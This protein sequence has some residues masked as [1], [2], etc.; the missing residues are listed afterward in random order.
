M[1]Q[2]VKLAQALVHDP[3]LVLLDEPTNGLDPQGRDEMLAL[4]QRVAHEMGINVILTSHVLADVERVANYVVMIS[5]GR[6]VVQGKLQDLM[7]TIPTISVRTHED[8]AAFAAAL[9]RRG[10]QPR[11]DEGEL[12]LDSQEARSSTLSVT[13]PWRPVPGSSLSSSAADPGGR[14]SQWRCGR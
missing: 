2:R 13:P 8:P 3:R 10:F 9:R 12:L 4:I 7:S 1:K 6:V 5:G 14:L 11:L